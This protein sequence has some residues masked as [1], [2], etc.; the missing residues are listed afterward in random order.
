MGSVV[1]GNLS[2]NMRETFPIA[3]TVQICNGLPREPVHSYHGWVVFKYRLNHHLTKMRGIHQY[4][5]F[6]TIKPLMNSIHQNPAC[7][8]FVILLKITLASKS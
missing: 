3:E 7:C 1:R 4:D 5:K 2:V 8:D 6:I